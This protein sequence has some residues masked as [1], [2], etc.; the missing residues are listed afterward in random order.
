ML[1]HLWAFESNICFR[2]ILIM[3]KLIPI[4]IIRIETVRNNRTFERVSSE[5]GNK[6]NVKKQLLEKSVLKISQMCRSEK[7]SGG[8]EK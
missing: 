4:K 1:R 8:G 3:I 6:L 7:S 2:T 5:I